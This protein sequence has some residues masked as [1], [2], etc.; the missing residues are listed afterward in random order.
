MGGRSFRAIHAPGH[1]D[2]QL[3]FYSAAERLLLCGD[4]VLLRISPNIGV[5]PSTQG[6]PLANYLGSLTELA[7]LEV[8]LALPGHHGP[9]TTW[10]ARIAEL[11]AHHAQRL[12]AMMAAVQD[13]A[14]ALEVSY[15]VF[16]YD[17][18]STHE[19]RFAVAETLA[20]LEYLAEQGRLKR[21]E[22]AER[23]LY[24]AALN[25]I[26]YSWSGL[27]FQGGAELFTARTQENRFSLPLLPQ[28]WEQGQGAILLEFKEHL[29]ASSSS[30]AKATS[31]PT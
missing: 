6:D 30:V 25:L 5:W 20:H 15:R 9:I 23:R 10:Q 1:A 18:F 12:E 8:A 13:G 11:K 14:T 29:C 16:N 31:A 22:G 26:R 17:R 27:R 19:V 28:C 21:V 7:E 3:V 2:G 24:Y 4:Q